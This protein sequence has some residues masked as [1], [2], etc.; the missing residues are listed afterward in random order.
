MHVKTQKSTISDIPELNRARK[1]TLGPWRWRQPTH[2]HEDGGGWPAP[3]TPLQTRPLSPPRPRNPGF[4]FGSCRPPPRHHRGAQPTAIPSGSSTA[5]PAPRV[6]CPS[7]TETS[8]GQKAKAA[9]GEREGRRSWNGTGDE[10][11]KVGPC[12]GRIGGGG[13]GVRAVDVDG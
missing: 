4:V 8:A 10:V 7:A 12:G 1:R 2:D 13:I 3:A 9:D 11:S 5:T 6:S